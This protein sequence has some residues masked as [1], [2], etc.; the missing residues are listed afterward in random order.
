M[1]LDYKKLI[2]TIII[3]S[4]LYILSHIKEKKQTIAPIEKNKIQIIDK[5]PLK[6]IAPKALYLAP[7]QN[8]I[9]ITN[10]INSKR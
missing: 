1:I 7:A 9:T 3:G 6:P 4:I 8:Y 2:T 5:K 10:N